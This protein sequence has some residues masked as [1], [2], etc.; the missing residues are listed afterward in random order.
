MP[1]GMT[2]I[3]PIKKDNIE[4]QFTLVYRVNAILLGNDKSS[5]L[6]FNCL[7]TKIFI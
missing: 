5:L 7:H 1:T 6:E 3:R 2:F 4:V